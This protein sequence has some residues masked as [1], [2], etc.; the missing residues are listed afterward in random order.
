MTAE[1]THLD[2]FR[3]QPRTPPL[4]RPDQTVEF[5]KERCRQ[6]LAERTRFRQPFDRFQKPRIPSVKRLSSPAKAFRFSI[7]EIQ[8][9]P[10]S[11]EIDLLE[12]SLRSNGEIQISAGIAIDLFAR[13]GASSPFVRRSRSSA[14][15]AGRRARCRGKCI[16]RRP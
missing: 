16:E 2:A 7:E 11:G 13:P 6:T 12:S 15:T 4:P 1:I 3:P 10:T 9:M 14:H 8:A 5:G